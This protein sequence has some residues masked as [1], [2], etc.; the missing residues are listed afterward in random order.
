LLFQSN[1]QELDISDPKTA[2]EQTVL[3][4]LEISGPRDIAVKEYSK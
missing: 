2:V 1:I 4:L 3:D